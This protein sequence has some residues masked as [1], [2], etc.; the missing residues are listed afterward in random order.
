M[1]QLPNVFFG[2]V[3]KQTKEWRDKKLQE[4]DDDV[5]LKETPEDV[6]KMLGFDPKDIKKIKG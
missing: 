3:G 2:K 1:K 4:I 6:L 5:E